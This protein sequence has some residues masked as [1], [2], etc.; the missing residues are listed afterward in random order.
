M[1]SLPHN[2]SSM[3]GKGAKGGC[4]AAMANDG[5]FL[6][7]QKRPENTLITSVCDGGELSVLKSCFSNLS[8]GILMKN[9]FCVV[10]GR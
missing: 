10:E 9:V 1:V 2:R 4:G 6:T 8:E 3:C 7:V 5:I